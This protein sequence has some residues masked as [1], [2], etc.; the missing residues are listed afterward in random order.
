MYQV[1]YCSSAPV[2][3]FRF[4]LF[5]EMKMKFVPPPRCRLDQFSS[6]QFVLS[7]SLPRIILRRPKIPSLRF[8]ESS[9]EE[10]E[11]SLSPNPVISSSDAVADVAV[12]ASLSFFFC[13]AFR[14]KV[15]SRN[16]LRII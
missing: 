12:E 7:L 15:S 4:D 16:N 8:H 1:R 3:L 2:L 9:D 14:G 6:V 5:V 13:L 10:A 11:A